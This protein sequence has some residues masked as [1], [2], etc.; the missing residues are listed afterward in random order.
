MADVT[1]T[2]PVGTSATSSLDE[3]TYQATP[4]VALVTPVAGP[5]GGN[6]VVTITGTGFVGESAVKFGPNTATNVTVNSATSITAWS[7]PGSAGAVKVTV[8]T[9]LGTGTD[10]A[11]FTYEAV[12]TVTAL[13]VVSGPTA[14]GT[15][16]NITGTNFTGA[17]VVSFGATTATAGWTVASTTS[18]TGAV[19]PA[20]A[21]GT[22][23]VTVTT[24]LGASAATGANQY[25]YSNTTWSQAA[26]SAGA[27]AL[28]KA[29]RPTT[30]PPARRSCSAVST[31]ARTTT[32][33]G[34]GT[35]PTGYSSARR[36]YHPF[37]RGFPRLPR[38]P[39]SW[40]CSA[41]TTAART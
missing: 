37:A 33:H 3:F 11:A 8:T 15:T 35:A 4:T 32:T 20:E 36:P 13:S 38:P 6:T 40:S 12:P 31:A 2:T 41:G 5:V 30:R 7:P 25:T 16:V 14:G 29:P 1:V 21:A 34:T 17:S 28:A 18:I 39:A 22:V 19:A 10:A 26:S 24:P 23:N 9:P 27:G